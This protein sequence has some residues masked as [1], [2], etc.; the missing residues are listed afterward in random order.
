M[1]EII[2]S[3]LLRGVTLAVDLAH[4]GPTPSLDIVGGTGVGTGLPNVCIVHMFGTPP[5]SD[6]RLGFVTVNCDGD[7]SYYAMDNYAN[8][9]NNAISDSRVGDF[10][11]SFAGPGT[12]RNWIGSVGF[13]SD[14]YSANVCGGGSCTVSKTID[15]S[16]VQH[17]TESTSA[18]ALTTDCEDRE[19]YILFVS[20]TGE[21]GGAIS[22]PMA[23]MVPGY[24]TTSGPDGFEYTANMPAGSWYHVGMP[25]IGKAVGCPEGSK[26]SLKY[27]AR[28]E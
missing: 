14:V 20:T 25:Y 9:G 23:K 27:G 10:A 3:L 7:T 21:D 2:F 24:R 17:G 19:L 16:T 6:V 8:E 11:F 4:D 5:S 22:G 15:L 13:E 26:R 1:A 12:G 18:G 28:E